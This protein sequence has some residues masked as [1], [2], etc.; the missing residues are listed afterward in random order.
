MP[1]QGSPSNPNY[2]ISGYTPTNPANPAPNYTAPSGQT[3][4]NRPFFA[5]PEQES[6]YQTTQALARMQPIGTNVPG[7]VSSGDIIFG[8]PV[9]TQAQLSAAG[10]KPGDT[11]YATTA[12]SNIPGYTE[13]SYGSTSPAM[14]L[15][16]QNVIAQAEAVRRDTNY[17]VATKPSEKQSTFFGEPQS[18]F[19]QTGK[20]ITSSG[21]KSYQNPMDTIQK[22]TTPTSF[23][24][25]SMRSF[26][27]DEAGLYNLPT[28]FYTDKGL[29]FVINPNDKIL[30]AYGPD[31]S[32]YIGKGD[33]Y[34]D[35][36]S[37]KQLYG[38]G[39]FKQEDLFSAFTN[40]GE[41]PFAVAAVTAFSTFTPS[42]FFGIPLASEFIGG[43]LGLQS[44]DTMLRN[45]ETRLSKS[46]TSAYDA[47]G[48]KQENFGWFAAKS[49]V[50]Q[51]SALPIVATGIGFGAGV[52][53]TTFP[54][55]TM[56]A[57]QSLASNLP[58]VSQTA[59]TA[60][61]FKA[62]EDVTGIYKSSKAEG[63]SPVGDIASYAA[64]QG[65]AFVGIGRGLKLGL[66]EGSPKLVDMQITKASVRQAGKGKI[67]SVKLN[68]NSGRD[69]YTI[70]GK[71]RYLV[72][73]Q[74]QYTIRAISLDKGI[75]YYTKTLDLPKVID[76]NI[77]L[78][79]NL[80]EVK[81]IGDLK[82]VFGGGT[83]EQLTRGYQPVRTSDI[84]FEREFF[85]DYKQQLFKGVGVSKM[86]VS[87]MLSQGRGNVIKASFDAIGKDILGINILKTSGS[88][89]AFA[90]ISG[91][92]SVDVSKSIFKIQTKSEY[93]ITLGKDYIREDIW[94]RPAGRP[95]IARGNSIGATRGTI[96]LSNVD[97]KVGIARSNLVTGRKTTPSLFSTYQIR[98]IGDIG[99]GGSGSIGG[100][101]GKGSGI[102][103]ED[104]G[105]GTSTS[106]ITK[107]ISSSITKGT[108]S[109]FT[110]TISKVKITPTISKGASQLG[111]LTKMTSASSL[112]SIS[113]QTSMV[114]T[115][116]LSALTPSLKSAS[117]P[118]VL[119]RTT[120][121]TTPI[122]TPS[123]R[124]ITTPVTT[125]F[126]T[127][128]DVPGIPTTPIT[129]VPFIPS[130]FIGLPPGM[131][132]YLQ[133]SRRGL[134][135]KA[136][137]RAIRPSFTGIVTKFKISQPLKVS[138]NFGLSP[139]AIRGLP[140]GKA[141]KQY[142]KELDF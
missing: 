3:I 51:L 68:D 80:F 130:P 132:G 42:N 89:S 117:L 5:T 72:D 12:M 44:K 15:Q 60:I 24:Q 43:G 81:N 106:A 104:I 30:T 46:L 25:G 79:K 20:Y 35:I 74:M 41:N 4:S 49:P 71:N 39:Q 118:A 119:T 67:A 61:S 123:L 45:V 55:Q 109:A 98:K 47:A 16:R 10:Y 115:K 86:S 112:V 40:K 66:T 97:I 31:V 78:G 59:T 92:P 8:G 9:P 52:L 126:T 114:S 99:T 69:L 63:L 84:S 91:T 53:A 140:T 129:F 34:V 77:P 111:T 121:A 95:N 137:E 100:G 56:Y 138:K 108:S 26:T 18:P 83:R 87:G 22:V 1:E 33:Y 73:Q 94:L 128:V 122:T 14:T 88:K 90:S 58:L 48:N 139:F 27:P 62:Y 11:V 120:V 103:F 125:P 54:L 142:F 75:K 50:V 93:K 23:L 6:A 107:Q 131:G 82:Y 2:P 135:R 36:F 113:S 29:K 141:K 134:G 17:T 116:Q 28:E 70:T 127:I 76:V 105:A 64:Y 124:A 65:I 37:G 32:P 57:T 101:F 13:T 19:A 136:K 102:T 110:P 96:P 38:Q 85:F 133:P 7:V 21:T